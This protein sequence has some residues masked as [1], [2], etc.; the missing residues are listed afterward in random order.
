MGGDEQQRVPPATGIQEQPRTHL[1]KGQLPGSSGISC[2]RGGGESGS[3]NLDLSSLPARVPMTSLEVTPTKPPTIQQTPEVPKPAGNLPQ[4]TQLQPEDTDPLALEE[5]L[6]LD[7]V[8]ISE[9]SASGL[10]GAS[11]DSE[12]V[13]LPVDWT[14]RPISGTPVLMPNAVKSHKGKEVVW[15]CD[16]VV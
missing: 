10:K 2:G 1:T 8:E 13:T 3:Q 14:C 6:N 16:H 5:A 15:D 7:K 9:L 4:L 11:L 12:Q